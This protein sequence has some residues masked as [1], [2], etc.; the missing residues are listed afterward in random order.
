MKKIFIRILLSPLFIIWV[1]ISVIISY[2]GFIFSPRNTDKLFD[3]FIKN[4]Y[5]NI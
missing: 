4:I 3:W 2:I 5:K 1:L